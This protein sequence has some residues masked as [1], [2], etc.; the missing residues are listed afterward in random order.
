MKLK[1]RMTL[2]LCAAQADSLET[3]FRNP[4]DSA[5]PQTWWHWMNGNISREGITADLEAMKE[6]GL[7]GATVVNVDCDIPR[8]PVSFMSPEWRE[9]FKFAIQ[10]AAR[11]GLDIT[12]ENCAGWSSSGGPWNMPENAMQQVVSSEVRVNGPT[13]FDAVLPQPPA[14]LGYYRDIA[15]LAFPVSEAE[16]GRMT[17]YS[18]AASANSGAADAAKIMDGDPNTFLRLPQPAPDQP[19]FVQ[20]EFPT[21]YLAR[22]AGIVGGP[23]I[24]ECSGQ[25]L[26]SDDG[27]SFRVVKQFDHGRRDPDGCLVL[28]FEPVAARFWRVQFLRGPRP[29]QGIAVGE[30]R[31]EPRASIERFGRKMALDIGAGW[32]QSEVPLTPDISADPTGSVPRPEV[33]DLTSRLAPDGKL[34]WHAPAGQWVV[35]RLGHTP[36][37]QNNHP[38]PAEGR[39]LECDKLSKTALDAHWVGFM[40]K[41]LGDIGPLSA[42]TLTTSLIDSYEVGGQTWTKNFRAEF[43]KR[44]GY[45]LLTYLPVLAGRVVD[46]PAVTERFLWDFRRTI[47]DLIAENYFGHFAELCRQRGLLNAVEPYT[48]PFE[49]LQCGAA[50][51]IVMGEFWAGQSGNP[52]VKL[53]ASIAHIYGTP[54]VAAESFTASPEP[55]RWQNDPYSLKAL[56]DLMFC[57]GINRYIFH[58]YAMQPWTNRWPG[59]TMGQWGFHFER[60]ITWWKQGKGWMDY[61]SRCQFLLQQGRTVADIA[62]FTG[63]SA[64]TSMRDASPTPPAGYDYDAVNADVLLNGATVRNGRLTLTSGADYAALVLPADDPHMTPQLLRR[65]AELIRAG[66]TVVGAAPQRSPSLTGFPSCD[67]EV[68][69]LAAGIWGQCDGKTTV[70]NS[71]GRGWVI[72][73]KPLG[74]ILA[75]RNW[76][77]DFE[78]TGASPETRLEYAHRVV[79]ETDIYFVS[80]QRQQADSAEVTFRVSGKVPELWHADTGVIERAPIWREKDGRT[81]VRLTFDPAGSVF[82]VFRT[83]AAGDHAVAAKL[84][85]DWRVALDDKGGLQVRATGDGRA[86]FQM[87]GHKTLQA[88]AT[89]VPAPQTVAGPWQLSFPPNWGAPASV[90]LEQLISWPDHADQGVRFFSGTA[91]Y[92][93]EIGIA[94][95]RLQAERE[96]WLDLGAVKNFAEVSL[97]GRDLGV[98]WKPPFRVNVTAAAR[99]GKNQLAIKVTNLW[100]N[101]LIGDEQLPPDCEWNKKQLAA[102]PQ[103]LLEGKPSPTGRLTFTT[104]HH[105]TKNMQPLPSGLLGPVR[106]CTVETLSAN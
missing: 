72:W 97:N 20:L 11:L 69:T 35:L 44:R 98:L 99:P 6:I 10:E 5:K 67:A 74:E 17:D 86:D 29:G 68:K 47:A 104:W 70:E 60:T 53:A 8:G 27:K 100:P 24:D 87:A 4:P 84:D 26:V 1:L 18:P 80:N 56:G 34:S 64:P 58:R 12:V 50:A 101:R 22:T 59:M 61:I 77:P 39:G 7:G 2:T 65:I 32:G 30:I 83:T 75:A 40:G 78:F 13:H 76:K 19:Q 38:A 57:Q 49:S 96:L 94:A 93:K 95:E 62:Y 89:N 63:E 46:N 81:T 43:Q 106:L 14:K 42:K 103:W 33:I 54:I 23:E 91:I 105:W 45:D 55:G 9:H 36:T 73:G 28:P 82:V 16:R 90:T 92:Q 102:W 66:A 52:S 51:D 31:L 71:S 48:G 21:P 85:A 37:G 88:V 3:G 41:I 15:V 79:G 25:V